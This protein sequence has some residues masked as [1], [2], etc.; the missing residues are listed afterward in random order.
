M[1]IFREYDIRGIFEKDLNKESVFAIGYHLADVIKK[2]NETRVFIGYDARV[3]S[4]T[5]FDW[6]SDGLMSNGIEVFCIGMIPTPV[7]YFCT[8]HTIEQMQIKSSIMITGS[9]NPPEYNGFKITINQKPFYGQE[10]QALRAKIESAKIEYKAKNKAVQNINAIDMYIEYLSEH[11]KTL[12]DFK[13]TIALDYGNGVGALAMQKILDNLHI[14]HKDLYA[15]PNG[16][17]PNHHPDPSEEKNLEDLKKVMQQ[18]SIQIG[19]AFDGDA[20]RIALLTTNHSFKGD[21]LG[22][23]FARE[24]A[25]TKEKPL[26][27]GEVKC[28]QVMYDEINTFGKSF[29]YK[30]GHSN[31]KVKLKELDADLAVEMSGHIFFNDR[32][33]GYDDAIYAGLRALE[34]FLNKDVGQIEGAIKALPKLYSTPEEK[35]N[36]TEE[37]KFLAI[38]GLKEKLKNPPRDFPKIVEIVEIDGVR[39]I[40][41]QGWGL[42][43][44]SNT[45]PVLVTRFEAINET[46][47]LFY[48][49]ALL[50][51]LGEV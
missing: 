44:A 42:V 21:E 24:I 1:S 36:T 51:L 46:T 37:R 17:F 45:T 41:E 29:M 9:H 27:I 18:D 3:H 33:Y 15:E 14:K 2:E 11:F 23:L 32:Y 13:Y 49:K 28:S 43:R 48:K 40:F 6:L 38:E 22:V 30:T 7:A 8:Y 19:L 31:L 5:L 35:I 4:L 34:L 26:I 50:S 47:A 20:D 10:I 16:N 39:V 12:K 25:Q